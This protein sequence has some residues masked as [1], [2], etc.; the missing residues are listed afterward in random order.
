MDTYTD[1]P[2]AVVVGVRRTVR[3]LCELYDLCVR[4]L[5]L[6]LAGPEKWS[7]GTSGTWVGINFS[8]M[9]GILWLP[10][11]KAL[12][13]LDLTSSAIAGRLTAGEWRV[14]KPSP[15]Q[16]QLLAR[17][18]HVAANTPG[19]SLLACV[20]EGARPQGAVRW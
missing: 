6:V 14:V 16:Q 10:R 7:I 18:A 20:A 19:A 11:E 8:S 5:G 3:F 15:E 12:K 9:L 2:R 1:D 4:V 13:M 17:A